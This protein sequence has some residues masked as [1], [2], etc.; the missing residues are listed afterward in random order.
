MDRNEVIKAVEENKIIVIMRGLNLSELRES[1]RAIRAG[2][3]KCCEITYDSKGDPSDEETASYLEALVKEFPDMHIGSGT[4]L[5]EKQVELTARAGGE[6]IISP[7]TNVDVIKKTREL[8][9]VSMPGALTP[10]EATLAN[11]SGADFVK[12]FPNGEMKPSYLHA[13]AVPLSHIRF[14]AVG[15]VDENNA[16]EYIKCGAV[17]IGVASGIIDKKR[18]KA[19]E[20]EYLTALAKKYTDAL[21]SAK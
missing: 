9:L 17:G 4:V 8:G 15:G 16:A 7:D 2:G 13:V 12:L 3:I 19:G 6:F 10:S 14:L 21:A 5:T 18:I 20:Y 11:R 1:V